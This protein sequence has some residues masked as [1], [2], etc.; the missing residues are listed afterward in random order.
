M[1]VNQHG[2]STCLSFDNKIYQKTEYH[3]CSAGE[4]RVTDKICVISNML[5]HGHQL[6]DLFAIILNN[7][8]QY[9]FQLATYLSNRSV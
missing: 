2:T 5:V 9:Q 8:S 4:E 7:S 6:P 1:K 3:E